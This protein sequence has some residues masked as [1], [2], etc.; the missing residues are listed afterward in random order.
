MQFIQQQDVQDELVNRAV[1]AEQRFK[2]KGLSADNPRVKGV[3]N[4]YL[5][6][7]IRFQQRM[8]A[9]DIDGAKGLVVGFGITVQV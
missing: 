6:A 2:D 5:N 7:G 1:A 3:V 8:S 4:R 9:G